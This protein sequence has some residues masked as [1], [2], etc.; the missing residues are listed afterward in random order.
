MGRSHA[1]ER[2]R[3]YLTFAGLYIV[4]FVIALVLGG[5]SRPWCSRSLA[6]CSH[7]SVCGTRTRTDADA[8]DNCSVGREPVKEWSVPSFVHPG[9]DKIIKVAQ[10]DRAAG[11]R[12]SSERRTLECLRTRRSAFLK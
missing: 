9:S 5:P 10:Q 6:S 8:A 4:A 12:R 7:C 2:R 11:H 3:S 1:T